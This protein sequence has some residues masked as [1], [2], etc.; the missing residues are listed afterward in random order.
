MTLPIAVDAMGGDFAP[1]EIIAGAR[2]AV[3]ELGLSVTLIGVPELMG[4][5]LGLPVLA[6]TEVIAMDDDPGA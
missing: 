2:R 6:V 5:T 3:D 4:D 1:K